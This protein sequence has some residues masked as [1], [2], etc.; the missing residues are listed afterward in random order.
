LL[1]GLD[2]W[3][4][5]ERNCDRAGHVVVGDKEWW[6]T[7]TEEASI[8][9]SIYPWLISFALAG[10]APM[11]HGHGIRSEDFISNQRDAHPISLFFCVSNK[12]RKKRVNLD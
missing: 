4:L 2:R 7:A 8:Y 12:K 3:T 6:A 5:V 11:R 1:A 10:P 9:P